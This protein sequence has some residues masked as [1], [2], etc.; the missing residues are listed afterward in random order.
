[1]VHMLMSLEELQLVS[2]LMRGADW[3]V[4]HNDLGTLG[5]VANELVEHI[6]SPLRHDLLTIVDLSRRDPDVAFELWVTTRSSL[7]T[8]LCERA[9]GLPA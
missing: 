8:Y 7:H 3:A 2:D 1:M 9:E 4:A 6:S 5:A